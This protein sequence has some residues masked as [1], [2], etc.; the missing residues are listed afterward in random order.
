MYKTI[1]LDNGIRVILSH[2]P[3]M[4]SSTIGIWIGVGSRNEEAGISGISHF[5]E[6]LVFKGT[7]ARSNRQIKREIEGRGGSLN[8]FTT[9][10]ITCYLAKVSGRHLNIALG[11]LS[12]MVLN[13][14]LDEKDV[15]RERP[16]IIEEIKMYQDMP[17][18]HVHDLLSE[19]MWP[20]H[21]LG[22][23]VA[24]DIESVS[25]IRQEDLVGYKDRNYIY[26]NM[27]I[28][29]CG[30][31]GHDDLIKKIKTIYRGGTKK[32]GMVFSRFNNRQTSPEIKIFYT[33]TK[34][35]HLCIGL[36]SF[37]RMHK[38]RHALTLLHVILGANMSSRLFENVRE[39]RGLAYEI[40]TEIKKYKDT[41]A[42]I[43]K[44]G[45]EHG[46]A[47]EAVRLILKELKNIKTRPVPEKELKRAKEF[48]KVQLLLALEDT[49][50]HMVWLGDHVMAT[51]RLPDKDSIIKEVES[52]TSG[53][54]QRV[55]NDI[56]I[57][58]N[59]NIALIG[60]TDDRNG[61]EIEEELNLS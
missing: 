44:A 25:S 57:N 1:N 26:Q 21:P 46:K 23:N 41:G 4:E 11:V 60:P 52:V 35:S 5:L 27:A 50:T 24:G 9:E 53:D 56:F 45:T 12:D 58:K 48:F 13:A 36:R 59:L 15:E 3:H 7:P 39:K 54:L 29:S 47:K 19:L 49:L 16:V 55:A 51:G 34:Q 17:N 40:G 43:V 30:S 2:M 6:H 42:F 8:G 28:V 31:L 33:D 10:E 37:G 32:R 22:F 38:D 18:H 61:R 20:G 14:R